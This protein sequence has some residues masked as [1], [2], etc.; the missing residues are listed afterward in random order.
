MSFERIMAIGGSG[1]NA[2]LVRMNATASNL[3]NVG[4]V[5]GSAETAFRAQRPV[6]SALLTGETAG[7]FK[8]LAGGVRVA[9]IVTDTKP[10]E[11]IYE[12]GNSLA[13]E[14]GYVFSS[15]VSEI[16]ELVDAFAILPETNSNL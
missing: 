3:A 12:P 10:I 16:E 8:D 14:D 5:S 15:N 7:G 2:Q 4:V 13:N 6:F 1:L 11:Q 9:R